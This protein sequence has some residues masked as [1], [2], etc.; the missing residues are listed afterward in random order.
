MVICSR[1][2]ES[3][4]KLNTSNLKNQ[5]IET[6]LIRL[7]PNYSYSTQN[8]SLLLHLGSSRKSLFAYFLNEPISK[9][10]RPFHHPGKCYVPVRASDSVGWRRQI[11]SVEIMTRNSE[12]IYQLLSMNPELI[13]QLLYLL[14]TYGSRFPFRLQCIRMIEC[15]KVRNVATTL[16]SIAILCSVLA[17]LI[18]NDFHRQFLKHRVQSQGVSTPRQSYRLV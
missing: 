12:L 6:C 5:S 15:S 13:Y 18:S 11:L 1:Q 10:Y 14:L 8:V 16:H 3:S 7:R 9:L 2:V 4:I 17:T